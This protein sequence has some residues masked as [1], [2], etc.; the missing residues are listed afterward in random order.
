MLE[1]F[2]LVV[3]TVR[4]EEAVQQQIETT[5]AEDGEASEP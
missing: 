1:Q 3:N 5:P 2:E 4:M